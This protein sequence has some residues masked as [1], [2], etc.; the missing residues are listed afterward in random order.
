GHRNF[1]ASLAFSSDALTLFSGSHDGTIRVWTNIVGVPSAD[2]IALPTSYDGVRLTPG[3]RFAYGTRIDDRFW[4]LTVQAHPGLSVQPWS[5]ACVALSPDG[6]WM[7]GSSG[8]NALSKVCLYKDQRFIPAALHTLS[9]RVQTTPAFSP[10][11][12][13]LATLGTNNVLELY[14]F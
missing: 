5:L 4:W 1:V 13:Y 14:Q 10:D 7:L 12:R 6:R 3:A 9:A 11:G 8:A 2:E